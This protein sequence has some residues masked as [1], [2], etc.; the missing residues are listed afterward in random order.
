MFDLKDK[1][2]YYL[3]KEYGNFDSLLEKQYLSF[4]TEKLS[5]SKTYC[6]RI[7][8]LSY[9]QVIL[10]F[11]KN[12]KNDIKTKELQYIITDKE[13]SYLDVKKVIEK[14]KNYNKEINRLYLKIL[15][16]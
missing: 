14:Y 9:N 2:R 4:I 12:I 15:N 1:I 3:I 10:E 8:W 7:K 6:E 13:I 5:N 16:L 11:K